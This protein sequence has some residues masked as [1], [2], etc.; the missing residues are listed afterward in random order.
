MNEVTAPQV[1]LTEAWAA[2]SRR[3]R[4]PRR[5]QMSGALRSYL[6]AKYLGEEARAGFAAMPWRPAAAEAGRTRPGHR[7]AR[8]ALTGIRLL[9]LGATVILFLALAF[10]LPAHAGEIVFD[11]TSVLIGNASSYSSYSFNV[12]SGGE[13]QVN[14]SDFGWPSPLSGLTVEIAS[15]TQLLGTLKGSGQVDFALSGPGTYYAYVIGAAQGPLDI[16]AYCLQGDFQPVPL[17][18]SLSLL[19]GGVAATVWSMRRR[20]RRAAAHGLHAADGLPA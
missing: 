7:I 12:D 6:D 14:L 13:L 9:A 16:G 8:A 1:T 5:Y 19:L 3:A 15:P 2:R 4:G 11:D 20:G 17:P 10:A 18:A